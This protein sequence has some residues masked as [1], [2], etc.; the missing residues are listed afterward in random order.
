MGSVST[1]IRIDSNVKKQATAL[2]KGLGMTLSEA[3]N[4]FLRQSILRGGLPFAVEYP[5]ADKKVEYKPTKELLLAVAEANDISAHPENYKG[6][7]DLDEM[8]KDLD[9]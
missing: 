5:K 6:Y 7:D 3:T 2:F 9:S 4:I 8:W 1:N